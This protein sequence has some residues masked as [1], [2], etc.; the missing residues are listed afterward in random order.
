MSKN[1]KEIFYNA[2]CFRNKGLLLLPIAQ[3]GV[4]TEITFDYDNIF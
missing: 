1:R 4:T 2:R 3:N